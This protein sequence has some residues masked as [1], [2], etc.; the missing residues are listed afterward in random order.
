MRKLLLTAVLLSLVGCSQW[1]KPVPTTNPAPEQFMVCNVRPI[2]VTSGG[3]TVWTD[4]M[5]QVREAVVDQIYTKAKLSF[6]FLPAQQLEVPEW[7]DWDNTKYDATCS[8]AKNRAED[9]ELVIFFVQSMTYNGRA[10]G[11]LSNFPSNRN[12][13]IYQHGVVI[14]SYS[15]VDVIA[16]ELGHSFNLYH[17]WQDN[18]YVTDTPSSGPDDCGTMDKYCNIMSYCDDDPLKPECLGMGLTD[19]QAKI[20]RDWSVSYPRSL[21]VIGGT[22]TPSRV[23]VYTSNIEPQVD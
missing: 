2:V 9:G 23:P 15:Y 21:V 10:I 17:P 13:S 6:N 3:E 4:E 22:F 5:L 16:H 11:G 14:S 20:V 8:Y 18:A 12:E 19:Q 1:R 7:Y